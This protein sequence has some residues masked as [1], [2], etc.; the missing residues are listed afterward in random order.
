MSDLVRVAGIRAQGRHGAS[1]GERDQPQPFVV[2]IEVLVEAADDSIDATGDYRAIVDGVRRVIEDESHTLIETLAARIA[3]AVVEIQGVV[4]C[5]AVV[6]KPAAAERL[7]V[8]DVS[9]EAVAG[10]PLPQGRG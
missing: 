2:D 3:A 8:S 9:A 7:G 10:P 4:S 5:R 6:H 1:A